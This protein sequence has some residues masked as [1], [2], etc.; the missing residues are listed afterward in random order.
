MIAFDLKG[1]VSVSDRLKLAMLPPARRQ[2]LLDKVMRQA[3]KDAKANLKAQQGPDGRPWPK[4][5][6][7]R[8]KMLTKMGRGLKTQA[9]PNEAPPAGKTKRPRK[10]P[11][12]ISTV[13][14]KFIPRP[15]PENAATR[16]RTPLI[17]TARLPATRRGCYGN[18]GTASPSVKR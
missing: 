6:Q 10:T 2:R 7:G 5:K 9:N 11:S 16:Q 3:V 8:K 17:R 18:S 12:S 4:R 15:K 1:A 13:C 14:P